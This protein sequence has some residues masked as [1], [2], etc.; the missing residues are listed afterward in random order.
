MKPMECIPITENS[1][2]KVFTGHDR[3]RNAAGVIYL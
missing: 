2:M 3:T 1:D